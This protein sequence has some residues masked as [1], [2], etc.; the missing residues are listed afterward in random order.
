MKGQ[1]SPR[2]VVERGHRRV[3]LA[4]N[5][6]KVGR[7]RRERLAEQFLGEFRH[8][9]HILV[10]ANGRRCGVAMEL[11][12]RSN[13]GRNSGFEPS[14]KVRDLGTKRA[15]IDMGLVDCDMAPV[16]TENASEQRGIIGT[17]EQVLEHR[18][19]GQEDVGRVFANCLTRDDLVAELFLARVL[20]LPLYDCLFRRGFRVS[21]V[22]TEGDV[23]TSKKLPQSLEL[24]ICQGIH[25]IENHGPDAAGWS[26]FL[27]LR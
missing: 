9:R 26:L 3:L 18:V 6:I 20:A 10:G 27:E 17:Q 14:D 16:G 11:R 22:A 15:G 5:D 13:L 7:V 25:G 23:R 24:V 21:G 19:V 8:V 1:G 4:G 2:G 12:H